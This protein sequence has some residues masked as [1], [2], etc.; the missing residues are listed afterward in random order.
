MKHNITHSAINDLI[1]IFKETV[2]NNN[3]PSGAR[4]LLKTVRKVECRIV[5]PGRY[6]HFGLKN[7]IVKLV[8]SVDVSLFKN[9]KISISINADGLP[10]ANSSGSQSL[11]HIM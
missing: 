6:F 1:P 11:S 5:E 7:S 2:P 3:L 10:L 4:T 8:K 9:N